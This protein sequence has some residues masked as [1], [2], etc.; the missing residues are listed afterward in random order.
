[1]ADA[2]QSPDERPL[3]VLPA[4]LQVW[5]GLVWLVGKTRPIVA[6]GAAACGRTLWRHR[7]VVGAIT[8]RALWV[9]ALLLLV[10]GG[11]RLLQ[12]EQPLDPIAL[13]QTFGLGLGLCS[14]TVLLAAHRRIR[15]A[16]IALGTAHGALV[17]V[18]GSVPG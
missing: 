1:M 17:L 13:R 18:L 9:G 10:E 5:R 12:I 3:V 8:V 4:L 15:W 16:G 14:M 6:R 7:S 11:R 2:P